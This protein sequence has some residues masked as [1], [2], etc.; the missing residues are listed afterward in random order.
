MGIPRNCGGG[1]Q[2][3]RFV[4]DLEGELFFANCL[5]SGISEEEFLQRKLLLIYIRDEDE[6]LHRNE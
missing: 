1:C 4:K 5:D 3:W 2:G 6:V